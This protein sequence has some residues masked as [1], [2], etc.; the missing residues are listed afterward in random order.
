MRVDD[1]EF[2]ENE[3]YA[4]DIVVPARLVRVTQL[5]HPSLWAFPMALVELRT[6]H[7]ANRTPPRLS[8]EPHIHMRTP[9]CFG[10]TYMSGYALQG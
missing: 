3:V 7:T 6:L 8:E 2:E 1:A 10:L 5:S 9:E 4:I